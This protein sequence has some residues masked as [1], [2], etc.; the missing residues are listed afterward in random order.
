MEIEVSLPRRT[1]MKGCEQ[2]IKV[3]IKSTPPP[4]LLL[5]AAAAGIE[6][7]LLDSGGSALGWGRR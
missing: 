4:L 5:L 1:L 6:D 3:L 7:D 2:E